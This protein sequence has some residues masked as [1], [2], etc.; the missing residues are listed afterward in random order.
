MWT[1][2]RISVN[3]T[4]SLTFYKHPDGDR[5]GAAV[6]SATQGRWEMGIRI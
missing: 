3:K 4:A 6:V 2:Q 5:L 1:V